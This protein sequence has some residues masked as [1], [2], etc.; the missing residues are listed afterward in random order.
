MIILHH[1][2]LSLWRFFW[3]QKK[4]QSCSSEVYQI[5]RTLTYFRIK[6]R[7]RN[8]VL[9]TTKN[10]LRGCYV[11]LTIWVK[12]FWG[13][14]QYT[15]HM[16]QPFISRSLL[17]WR[18][19]FSAV[20]APFFFSRILYDIKY[21]CKNY[22]RINLQ[23]FNIDVKFLFCKWRFGFFISIRVFYSF[24]GV[25][26]E[27]FKTFGTDDH[28]NLLKTGV[29]T[30]YNPR[31]RGPGVMFRRRKMTRCLNFDERHSLFFDRRKSFHPQMP[32]I[33]RL[34]SCGVSTN[35]KEFLQFFSSSFFSFLGAFI[36]RD[37]MSINNR[38]W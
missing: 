19:S 28:P 4:L 33:L 38:V 31:E 24:S 36:F 9:Q 18:L 37:K 5:Q 23:C 20:T 10:I 2:H 11:H 22:L 1:I 13:I 21:S 14:V 15:L 35:F 8:Y 16:V 7:D 6:F 26:A 29:T 12:C 30:N 3:I 17:V 27:H 34:P 25:A 32:I